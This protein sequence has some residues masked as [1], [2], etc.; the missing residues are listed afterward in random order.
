MDGGEG[1]RPTSISFGLAQTSRRPGVR[2]PSSAVETKNPLE[3]NKD[4]DEPRPVSPRVIPHIDRNQ[5]A[6]ELAPKATSKVEAQTEARNSAKLETEAYSPTKFGLQIRKKPAIP[7]ASSPMLA[8]NAIPGL[9]VLPDSQRLQHD[10]AH[11]PAD[12]SA[13][14]YS[15]MPVGEFGAALLRGMGWRGGALGR[16]GGGLI[17]PVEVKLRPKGLGLG[18][19][20]NVIGRTAS[21]KSTLTPSPSLNKLSV[22]TKV[23][24]VGGEHS[25]LAG[26]VLEIRAISIRVKLIASGEVVSVD[27]SEVSLIEQTASAETER[28]QTGPSWLYPHIRIRF[29]AKSLPALYQTM[30]DVLD[31]SVDD[32]DVIRAVVRL[33]DGR[34]VSDVFQEQVEPVK[35][36]IG[37]TAVIISGPQR[38]AKGTLLSIEKAMGHLQLEDSFEI[39]NVPIQ[40]LCEYI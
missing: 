23:S 21:S 14:T 12:P 32:T 31:I 27:R 6:V 24:I 39:A 5:Y 17:R 3:T 11:R 4:L 29:I 13:S 10:L 25:G 34:L 18:A 38:G 33:S 30:G 9:A 26:F 2:A 40:Q 22:G 8:H 37:R 28:P 36:T 16:N 20:P 19:D 1:K 15:E 35:P 7:A